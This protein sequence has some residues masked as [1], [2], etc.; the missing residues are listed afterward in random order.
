ME[1]TESQCNGATVL[2]LSGRL[3]ALTSS[4]LERK[5]DALLGAD[6]RKLVFD[7]AR[8]TYASSAG[9]RVF[10]ATAKKLK[11]AGGQVAF[12]ALTPAVQEAFEASGFIGIFEVQPSAVVAA[13]KFR[14]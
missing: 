12:A 14:A 4:L 2:A 8:L 13:A 5:V 7:C 3:D 11:S 6:T 10:L 9:L 1:I